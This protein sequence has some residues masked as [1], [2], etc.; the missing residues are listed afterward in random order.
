MRLEAHD[1]EVDN[2]AAGTLT[3]RLK[4]GVDYAYQI[5]MHVQDWL[6]YFKRARRFYAFDAGSVLAVY[7]RGDHGEMYYVGRDPRWSGKWELPSLYPQTTGIVTAIIGRE[8]KDFEEAV[9]WAERALHG[10]VATA[11]VIDGD[12]VLA[13]W[14]ADLKGAILVSKSPRPLPQRNAA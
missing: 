7:G 13:A 6:H 4:N 8:V 11:V 9:Q 14:E 2:G 12:G 5:E 10:N 1:H 3:V